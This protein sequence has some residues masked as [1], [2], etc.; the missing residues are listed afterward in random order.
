MDLHDLKRDLLAEADRNEAKARRA[1]AADDSEEPATDEPARKRRARPPAQPPSAPV[2]ASR[3]RCRL[4]GVYQPQGGT[5]D[6]RC[7]SCG[8]FLD[9]SPT[10][11]TTPEVLAKIKVPTTEEIRAAMDRWIAE[12]HA[13]ERPPQVLMG[14]DMELRAM[15]TCIEALNT[16][17]PMTAARV[18]GYL[19]R[20]FGLK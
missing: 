17:P 1:S 8:S 13:P 7:F 19:V 11:T 9:A 20:R 5:K 4:C 10:K 18:A 15:G 3:A 16:L 2:A 12:V 14:E 6:G